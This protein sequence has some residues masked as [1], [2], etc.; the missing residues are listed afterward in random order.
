MS[1]ESPASAVLRALDV[2]PDAPLVNE[3]ALLAMTPRAPAA[4]LSPEQRAAR[5][6]AETAA[7]ARDHDRWTNSGWRRGR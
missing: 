7:A 4:P 3:P 1:D 2:D 5:D 6:A